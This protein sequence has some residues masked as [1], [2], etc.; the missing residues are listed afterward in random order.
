[1]ALATSN[2]WPLA[3]KLCRIRHSFHACQHL[4][5]AKD[6]IGDKGKTWYARHKAILRNDF[7]G[8]DRVIRSLRH[9]RRTVQGSG[10]AETLREV[11]TYFE[12]NRHRMSYRL[13][14]TLGRPIGSGVVE[15]ANKT[16]VTRRLKLSG[17]R[18]LHEGGQA[19]L[20]WRSLY[21]SGRF[22][23][24]W[25]HVMARL[26]SSAGAQCQSANDNCE[27]TLRVA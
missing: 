17:Q 6:A 9:Y 7:D 23:A 14:R 21:Q 11:Q 10:A 27:K 12:N 24:A 15:A 3:W 25:K 19:V 22:D 18:W 20:T 1:M 5:K 16:L 13:W 2:R 4:A 8:A 26:K